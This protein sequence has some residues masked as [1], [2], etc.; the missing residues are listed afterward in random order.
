M[1]YYNCGLR[2]NERIHLE[3][4][5]INFDTKTLHVRKGKNYKERFVPLTKSSLKYLE[6]YI[7]NHR[8]QLLKSDPVRSGTENRLFISATGKPLKGEGA[9]KRIKLPQMKTDDLELQQKGLTLH[10]LRNSIATHSCKP[11]WNYR[12]HSGF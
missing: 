11:E 5:D 2:R 1:V 8:P 4:N 10:N 6:D 7:Y 9:Y 12:K 3:L